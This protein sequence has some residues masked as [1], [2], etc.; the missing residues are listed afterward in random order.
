MAPTSATEGCSQ[1]QNQTAQDA[2][3]AKVR[4]AA[5]R[6]ISKATGLYRNS[7]WDLVDR[8]KDDPKFDITKVPEAA[9]DELKKMKPAERVARQEE[10][11]PRD[12][13][14]KIIDLTKSA[15]ATSRKRQRRRATRPNRRLTRYSRCHPR[16]GGRGKASRFPSDGGPPAD[17]SFRISSLPK[18]RGTARDEHA[19]TRVV[20]IED[21][22][23]I[24]RGVADALRATGYDVAERPTASAASTR[25]FVPASAS[26]C[27]TCC[28]GRWS[29][30]SS[31]RKSR[32]TFRHHPHRT[33][34]RGRPRPRPQDGG[35]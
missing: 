14:K 7:D 13:Q 23:P 20:V 5:G 33:R 29:D 1:A 8:M 26:S 18:R 30:L 2:N 3:A 21:E 6:A 31:A 10:A 19:Q 25:P 34:H 11:R 22:T 9:P 4:A 35:R 27:W 32:P 12:L 16:A 17:A 24:R 15:K 28:R